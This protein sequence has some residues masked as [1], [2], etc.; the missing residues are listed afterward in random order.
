MTNEFILI[1]SLI[2]EINKKKIIKE[3]HNG[4]RSHH[5][6]HARS[7][8]ILET[9]QGRARLVLGWEKIIMK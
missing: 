4:L 2:H 6:E 1:H 5:P 7:R 3:N 9:K 8:P